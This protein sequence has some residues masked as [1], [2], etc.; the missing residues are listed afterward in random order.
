MKKGIILTILLLLVVS[1]VIYFLSG[2]RTRQDK[3]LI[4]KFIPREVNYKAGF[5]I[6]TNSTFRI[7]TAPMYHNLSSVVFIKADSPNII[8]IKEEAVTWDDFFK[9]LPFKLTADCLTTGTKETFCTGDSGSLKFYLNGNRVDNLLERIIQNK[10]RA[11]ITFGNE[12]ETQIQ[13]QL[14]QVPEIK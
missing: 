11:L 4:Q 5:A 12:N 1:T 14:Q 3:T 13:M 8:N 10:D 7:F 9:T 6:F 2:Q